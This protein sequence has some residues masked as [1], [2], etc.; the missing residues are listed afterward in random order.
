MKNFLILLVISILSLNLVAQPKSTQYLQKVVT[1]TTIESPNA[2]SVVK[3][4]DFMVYVNLDKNQITFYSEPPVLI[5]FNSLR[6]GISLGEDYT[7]YY[8]MATDTNYNI[9]RLSMHFN[10]KNANIYTILLEYPKG[11]SYIY[12]VVK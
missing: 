8:G 6:E 1:L 7:S 2:E 12:T 11:K 4:C 5:D 10:K 3:T 9:F